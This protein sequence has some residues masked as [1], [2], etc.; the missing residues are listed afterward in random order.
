MTV[1]GADGDKRSVQESRLQDGGKVLR[2][3]QQTHH[4]RQSLDKLSPASALMCWARGYVFILFVLL[5]FA[6]LESVVMMAHCQTRCSQTWQDLH[7][8]VSAGPTELD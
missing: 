7:D 5:D 6:L 4:G 1:G 2:C 8:T 3:P